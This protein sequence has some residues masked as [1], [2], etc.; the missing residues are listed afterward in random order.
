MLHPV[1]DGNVGDAL[2]V[3]PRGFPSRSAEFWRA[4]LRRQ[5]QYHEAAGLGALGYLLRAGGADA[6]I[7]LTMRS[8]RTLPG[9]GEHRVVNLSS[10]YVGDAHRWLAPRMLQKVLGEEADL[11]TDLTPSEPVR[12]M[13]PQFGFASWHD[14][15]LIAAL[16][17]AA[18]QPG[19]SA[20]VTAAEGPALA[21][22]EPSAGRLVEDHLGLGCL[23]A[24][25]DHEGEVQ[26]LVFSPVRRRRLPSARL[27]Y[28]PS[29]AA[30]RRHIGAVARFLLARGILFLEIPARRGD[31]AF[32]A[33]FTT[34]PP[35]TFARGPFDPDAIDHAYS[36]FVFLRI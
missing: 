4:G 34:R 29:T 30:V 27:V 12:R 16:G 25:L 36:E 9:G 5:A 2:A 22:L 3:L 21:A 33:W 23:A 17:L 11:V 18:L 31:T 10:W 35:P 32:G 7:I 24:L 14:G 1:H 6:G 26:P 19:A 20:G 8:R 28:A 15:A 13:M